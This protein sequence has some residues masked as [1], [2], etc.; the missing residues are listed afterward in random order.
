MLQEIDD[1]PTSYTG[2]FLGDFEISKVI[3]ELFNLTSYMCGDDS[4]YADT[5]S[6]FS[7]PCKYTFP[8][9]VDVRD[10]HS[11]ENMIKS[12]PNMGNRNTYRYTVFKNNLVHSAIYNKD[13]PIIYDATRCDLDDYAIALVLSVPQ[14]SKKTKWFLAR[15]GMTVRVLGY[16]NR[17]AKQYQTFLQNFSQSVQNRMEILTYYDPQ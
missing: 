17:Q 10:V 2:N 6:P 16:G 7:Y 5:N 14:I 9:L 1:R 11:I 3:H 12:F 15:H 4:W 8:K 13:V